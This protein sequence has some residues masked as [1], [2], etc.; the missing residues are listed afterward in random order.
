MAPIIRATGTSR[1]SGMHAA[2]RA[3]IVNPLATLAQREDPGV[4][5]GDYVRIEPGHVYPH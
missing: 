1:R 5:R 2:A 3:R 4:N